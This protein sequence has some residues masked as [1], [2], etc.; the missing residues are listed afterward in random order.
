MNKCLVKVVIPVYSNKFSELEKRSLYQ[1]YTVLNQHPV[2]MVKPE[3]LDLSFLKADYPNLQF[4][5]FSDYYFKDIHG[6]NRLMLSPEFY[7]RFLDTEYIL[8]HQLDAYVFRDELTDWCSRGYDFIGAPW[9]N[10]PVNNLP[11]FSTIH[12][13]EFRYAKFRHKKNRHSLYNKVGNGGLSLRKVDSFM[14]ATVTHLSKIT[15]YLDQKPSH[16]YNEDVFWATEMYKFKYPDTMEALHFSFDTCPENSFRLIGGQLPF[17][18]HGWYKR[19]MKRFWKP[20]I[21][22]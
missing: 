3:S 5:S 2:V 14:I 11:V 22:F 8:I 4:E 18:C 7:S 13:L 17:G 19:K 6:Y 1:A 15:Y 21:G 16:L 10:N 20:I 12:Q 9:L